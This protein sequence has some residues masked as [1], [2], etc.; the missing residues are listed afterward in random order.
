MIGP[1]RPRFY[2]VMGR[3]D[4]DEKF[5]ALL[6]SEADKDAIYAELAPVFSTRTTADWCS[7]LSEAG[8]RH[9][10]V[11]DYAAVA[12]DPSIW[13]NGYL[14]RAA[15]HGLEA[16]VVGT[17]VRFSD[18]PAAAAGTAPELGQHTEEVLIELG[19]TWDDIALFR[20]A[21]AI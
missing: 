12:A 16:D 2:Q 3:V 11:R 19:Y 13:E 5:P 10:A 8:I 7:V 20:E 18:T 21:G 15:D 4:L 9:A 6:Y 1:A 17:P 14:L